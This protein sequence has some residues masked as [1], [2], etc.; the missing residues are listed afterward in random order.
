MGR[1]SRLSGYRR[2]MTVPPHLLRAY[3]PQDEVDIAGFTGSLAA[4]ARSI[5]ALVALVRGSGHELPERYDL[6]DLAVG[7]LA[8]HK[9]SRLLTKSSVTAPLRAPFTEFEGAAGSG[10]H[11]E[12]PRG[13]HGFRHTVG[14]LV[15]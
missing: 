3:D 1:G 5:A 8:T 11:H 13:D 14:E 12:S 4:Y 6:T 9:L 15:T 7:G 2:A 10:E